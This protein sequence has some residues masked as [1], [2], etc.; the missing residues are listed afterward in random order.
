MQSVCVWRRVGL[1]SGEKLPSTAPKQFN[2][3]SDGLN[4]ST[5][6]K[7]ELS[8]RDDITFTASFFLLP[9]EGS[10][11]KER[12]NAFGEQNR[13]SIEVVV[14]ILNYYSVL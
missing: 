1:Y 13:S 3:A 8:D 4:K 5:K 2:V 10:G 14:S 12:N 7:V 6:A 9:E 11:L